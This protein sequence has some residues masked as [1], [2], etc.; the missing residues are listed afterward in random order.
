MT[1]DELAGKIK[2]KYPDYADMDNQTLVEKITAKH[3][4]YKA[5]LDSNYD[6]SLAGRDSRISAITQP[7]MEGAKAGLSAALPSEDFNKP[8]APTSANPIMGAVQ[9]AGQTLRDPTRIS[10]TMSAPGQAAGD[11]VS[12]ALGGGIIGKGAGFITSMA[13]DPQTYMLGGAAKA[14]ATGK[15]TEIASQEA[16]KAANIMPKTI[17]NM[18]RAGESAGDKASQVGKMLLDDGVLKTS[19]KETEKAALTKL[20][21]HGKA[22]GKAL[23]DIAQ[24][25]KQV[26]GQAVDSEVEHGV[27]AHDALKPLNETLQGFADSVTDARKAL[28]KPFEN[29][30][31]WL[32]TKAENQ[33]GKLTLDNVK[34]IME[35]IGPMTRKGAEDTQASM[36][37]LYGTL[38]KMRDGMVE[39]IAADSGNPKLGENLLKA[40]AGYSTYLHILPDIQRNAVKEALG[41]G[42]GLAEPIKY[43]TKKA[44]PLIAKAANEAD[45]GTAS[46][47]FR[48]G[49]KGIGSTGFK[50]MRGP[51]LQSVL[52]KMK[53]SQ[54]D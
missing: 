19:A 21:E 1:T 40:N 2:A 28:A 54:E 7:M 20:N 47:P 45:M 11:K 44:A 53:S 15:L 34:H 27:S 29:V 41:R 22:V 3:P 16:N 23:D 13:L 52:D 49:I 10:P 30:K 50:L 38:A 46:V 12:E 33:G 48:T 32:M 17:E 4:E 35:E 36:S 39:S 43:L 18:T 9:A 14:G 24:A 51:D 37:E 5:Q 42:P 26:T 25:S 8:L 6:T 31:T